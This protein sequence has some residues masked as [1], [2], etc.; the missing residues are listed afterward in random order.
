VLADAA[1]TAVFAPAPLPLVFAKATLVAVFAPAL[2]PQ[3]LADAA[4]PAVFAMTPHPPVLAEAAAANTLCIYSSAFGAEGR[5]LA[6]LLG[7]R[8]T[9]RQSCGQGRYI[10]WV[11]T[12]KGT[13]GAR[14]KSAGETKSAHWSNLRDCPIRGSA[15]SACLPNLGANKFC[16]TANS[17]AKYEFLQHLLLCSVSSTWRLSVLSLLCFRFRVVSLSVCSVSLDPTVAL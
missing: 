3:V 2:L 6:G 15:K 11:H 8:R 12:T 14:P 1:F 10:A 9:W 13:I 4:A 17:W 7:C 16:M 5:S